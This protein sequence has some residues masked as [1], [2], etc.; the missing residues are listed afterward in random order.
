MALVL[1]D[2]VQE[3]TTTSGTG[4]ITLNGAVPGFQDFLTGIGSGNTTFYTIYDPTTYAWEVGI[5]TFTSSGTDTLS[6]DTVLSNSLGTTSQINLAGNQTNVFVTYP[7]E[8]SVNL[9]SS[10]NVSPLGTI[11]SGTWQGSTVGVAY[12]GTGV[13][14][15]SGANSVVL[16]DTNQNIVANKISQS[17]NNVTASGGTTSLT[18]SSAFWQTLQGTGTH[19]IKLPDATTL[20]IGFWYIFDNDSTGN[21]TV[22]DFASSTLDVVPPGGYSLFYLDD[23]SSVAGSWNRA[24]LIPSDVNWGTNSLDLGGLTVITNGTWQGNAV[25]PAYGGTG[26]TT[27]SAANN[28]L[29]STGATT[30]TAGTL[31]VAAG[32]TGITSLT[33]NYIPYGNGTSP[34]QSS[35]TFTYNGTTLTAANYSTPG[36]LTFTGTG[37]RITGDLTATVDS[38]AFQTSVTN[39]PTYVNAIPNGTNTFAGFLAFND[40]TVSSTSEWG[41]FYVNGG[42][43]PAFNIATDKSASGTYMPMRFLTGGSERMR[44]DT[45]GNVGIGLTSPSGKFE[46]ATGGSTSITAALGGTF[47][48]YTYRNGSGSWFHAGKHPSSDYFYIG[49]GATPTTTIDMVVDPSGNVGIGTS[50]PSYK[51]DVAGQIASQDAYLIT[52]NSSG[53]PS[54][55]AFIFRP[56]SNTIALGTASTERMRIT[57]SGEVLIGGTSSL[58]ADLG[59]YGGALGTTAGNQVMLER[60]NVT[61]TNANYLEISEIRT[62]AGSD[63]TTSG[64]RIQRKIDATWHGY[65]QFGGTGVGEGITFGTGGSTV[66]ANSITE[67]MRID[68][69]G[70]VGIGTSSPSAKL[71]VYGQR[72]R[73]NA[74]P[75][76]GIEFANT[77]AV[78]GYV[79][80][81]TTNDV[82]TMRHA[83]STGISVGASG[84]LGVGGT[85]YGTAGQVLTSNGASAAPS[86]QAAAG[87]PAGTRMSFQQTSAPTGWTKD[88]TAA[89]NDSIMRIVTGS[90]SSGGSTAFSTFN[91]QTA[92][93]ATTLSTA[94]MPS[95]TH[96]SATGTATNGNSGSGISSSLAVVGASGATGGGGSHTHSVTTSL[97]YYD[98]IIASKD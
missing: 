45:S 15:S 1:A 77:A 53:T 98:F 33:A 76:P 26:L 27:F 5:G 75:D 60:T 16:R 29:Y 89:L 31:P 20:P 64:S 41:G 94:Q 2:R 18:S 55:G 23:I 3:I 67:R 9:D 51:L 81:D 10:G 46:V 19:T 82:M 47:P 90:A 42:G 97:K 25:A 21:L 65:I 38:V 43:S 4:T 83:S 96:N 95:H 56:A 93:G 24:G 79:F 11:A 54:A 88:T 91:G 85:N 62:S 13:T 57:S 37:N 44:I 74:T 8:K 72:I 73:I 78:K 61:S 12:G 70:N 58:S 6:R 39:G 68:S 36:N 87:F 86:W 22:Q 7:S 59:I 50:S 52:A 28:A 48:A 63:W 30:L 14:T 71:E 17:V 34:Y 92:T 32:G 49:H 66:S 40:N 80:Y 84:Q 69:S 35:S